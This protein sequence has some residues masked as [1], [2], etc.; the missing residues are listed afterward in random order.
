MDLDQADIFG[1]GKSQDEVRID[2]AIEL[3]TKNG[4]RVLDTSKPEE[5]KAAA[6]EAGYKVS[7]PI[8]VNGGVKT[9]KDLRNYFYMRLW[10]K[11][12]N[13]Q[14]YHVDM[15]LD[16]ELRLFKLFVESREVM[17]LS[18]LNAIQEC[19]AIIDIIFD[20][21]DE[22]GFRDPIDVR[23]IGQGKAG[24]ITRKAV[25]ILNKK[26]QEAMHQKFN[27][28]VEKYEQDEKIDLKDKASEL[29]SL[30]AG[31]EDTNG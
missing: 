15:G 22:F 25:F 19:V 10:K 27:K 29:D 6:I 23:V 26:V 17:G 24:W 8:F 3:L 7:D 30:L 14:A 11:Y 31:M 2:A 1:D 9:L 5:A 4:Y 12:P 16:K 18:R 13:R 20:H 21:E 28:M